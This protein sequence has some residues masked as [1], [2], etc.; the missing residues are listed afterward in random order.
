ML[1]PLSFLKL[2]FLNS[3]ICTLKSLTVASTV[4]ITEYLSLDVLEAS[5]TYH[6]PSRTLV[7]LPSFPVISK[8]S[9]T[10]QLPT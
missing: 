5:Q 6:V 8:G 10:T 7:P 9:V 2:S 4:Y 1:D 3:V